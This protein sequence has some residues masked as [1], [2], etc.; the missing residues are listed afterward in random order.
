MTQKELYQLANVFVGKLNEFHIQA[1]K[2]YVDHGETSLALEILCDYLVDQ[3]VVLS[4]HE[5]QEITRLGALLKLD[6][7]AGRFTYLQTLMATH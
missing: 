3:D 2:E 6:I 7:N 5:Y 4:T 1:V